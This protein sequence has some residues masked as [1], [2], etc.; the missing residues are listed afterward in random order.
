[1]VGLVFDNVGI[2]QNLGDLFNVY[3]EW[4]DIEPV[5][6]PCPAGS[7]VWHNGLAAHG[8][9]ANFTTRPRPAMTCAYMPEGSRFNGKRNILPEGHFDSLK[10]GDALDDNTQNPL[11]WHRT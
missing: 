3:P 4:R 8:A 9:G 11:V 2:G 7:M 1:M 6:S 5:P 10:I